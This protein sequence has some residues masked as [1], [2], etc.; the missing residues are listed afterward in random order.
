MSI[1]TSEFLGNIKKSITALYDREKRLSEKGL[2]G[3]NFWI[4]EKDMTEKYDKYTNEQ[5]T[6][7]LNHT[8]LVH[9]PHTIPFT[10]RA[11]VFQHLTFTQ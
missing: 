2:F 4:V 3:E 5:L 9:L 10:L 11:K 8:L 6:A 1:F 7:K